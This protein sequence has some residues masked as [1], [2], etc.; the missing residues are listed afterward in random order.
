M[1]YPYEKFQQNSFYGANKINTNVDIPNINGTENTLESLIKGGKIH[2]NVRKEI[3]KILKPGLSVKKL[4]DTIESNTKKFTNGIGINNGIGFPSSLS[5]SNCVAHYTPYSNKDIIL[6]EH[7]NIKIDFG[8]VVNGWIVDCAFSAY[9]DHKYDNLHKAVKEATYNGIKNAG[10]DV[11]IKDWSRYNKEV[12]ESYEIE[13]KGETYKIKPIRNLGGHNIKHGKIHGGQF[14]PCDPRNY[15]S[16]KRFGEGV[17]AI[18]TFGTYGD[19]LRIAIENKIE[20]SIY[21]WDLNNYKHLN[22]LTKTLNIPQD[23]I[24]FIIKMKKQFSTLP[25][26]DRFLKK[27][28]PDF[29]NHIKYLRKLNIVNNFPPLYCKNMSAQY[30]HT[31]FLSENKKTIVSKFEDY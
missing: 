21:M 31:I 30:E 2:Y 28:D 6:R 10:V 19:N 24:D 3:Q 29:K 7:D 23:K 1:Y 18:E 14:L 27:I 17:Y 16:S 13:D 22:R 4:A 15:D 11:N 12:M 20:N 5:V 8:V 26:C 9:F 25:F